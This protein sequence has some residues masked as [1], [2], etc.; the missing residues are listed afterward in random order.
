MANWKCSKCNADM[1]KV[2]DIVLTYNEL[3]LPPGKGYRC[4]VCGVEFLDGEYVTDELA[5]AEQ[6]LL[7][8]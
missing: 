1:E 8:K 2:E 7:G 5:A 3:E 6:M 4:P